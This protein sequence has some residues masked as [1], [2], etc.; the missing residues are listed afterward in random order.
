V[1]SLKSALKQSG[2]SQGECDYILDTVKEYREEGMSGVEAAKKAMQ[3][4]IDETQRELK[5][6]SGQ[7]NQGQKGKT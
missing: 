2:L 5:S 3:D 6:V 4:M 7:I 1:A